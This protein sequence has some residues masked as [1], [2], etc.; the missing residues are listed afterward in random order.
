MVVINKMYSSHYSASTLEMLDDHYV[1]RDLA[2]SSEGEGQ[3][4]SDVCLNVR[5]HC[6][7]CEQLCN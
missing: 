4:G 3:P 6:L 7:I 2:K 1:V 5:N